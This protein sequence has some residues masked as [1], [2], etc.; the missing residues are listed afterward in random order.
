MRLITR[1]TILA[2]AVLLSVGTSRADAQDRSPRRG[3]RAAAPVTA[4]RGWMG[5]TYGFDDHAPRTLVVRD[6]AP[7]SPAARA[8]LQRGDT[9][10]RL[11]GKPISQSMMSS[12]DL[13]PGDTVRLNVRRQG[14]E[15]EIRVVAEPRPARLAEV[16]RGPP[17]RVE[18]LRAPRRGDR[19]III[20]GD[21][22]RIGIDSLMVRAD[23][24]HYRLRTFFANS[25]GPHLRR[26]ERDMPDIRL[27]VDGDS[28]IVRNGDSIF[29][30]AVPG[31][32]AFDFNL[33]QRSIAGAEFSPLNPGL[34][35]YFQT[36]E[37]LLVLRVAP[38]TPAARAGLEA[39]DVVTQVNGEAVRTIGELRRAVARAGREEVRLD[40]VRKGKRRE[41]RLGR[42]R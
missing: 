15:R 34:A 3:E 6:V 35:E 10:V 17:T 41:L 33:G 8:G 21:T 4:P 40:V 16:R 13:K 28:V 32:F 38:R 12:L 19:I 39:G 26:L 2:L 1:V 27:R 5:F 7:G 30:R 11:N 14:R 37:G 42:E 36:R 23:S 24:L 20:D 31:D 22:V 25:L 18:V 9:L 29:V